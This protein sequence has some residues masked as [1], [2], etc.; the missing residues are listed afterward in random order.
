MGNNTSPGEPATRVV[1]INSGNRP[2]GLLVA[3]AVIFILGSAFY[4]FRDSG[5]VENLGKTF[6]K[7]FGAGGDEFVEVVN[8]N[9]GKAG[10]DSAEEFK[11]VTLADS[12]SGD[13]D[14]GGLEDFSGLKIVSVIFDVEGSDRGK[15]RVTISN[16]GVSSKN[17]NSGSIQYLPAG[18]DFPKIKK[19]NFESGSAVAGGAVFVVGMNCHSDSVCSGVNMSWSEALNNSG[20][21]IF[22]A[23]DQERITDIGDTDVVSRYEYAP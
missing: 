7:I 1:K 19:K 10:E 16:I 14:S 8:L 18:S 5:F 15:E 3:L 6:G 12:G 11:T 22:L 20:G 21:S 13:S 23:S 4:F 2:R 9:D 17:L